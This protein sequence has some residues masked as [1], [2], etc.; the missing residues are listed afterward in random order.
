MLPHDV[1]SLFKGSKE[2]AETFVNFLNSQI[3][4]VIK[5]T[6]EFSEVEVNFLDIKLRFKKQDEKI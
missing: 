6:F 3:P 5:Y 1:W 2:E 4:G